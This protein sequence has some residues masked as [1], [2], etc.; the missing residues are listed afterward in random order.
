[1]AHI[2]Q[3]QLSELPTINAPIIGPK[4]GPEKT[5][6]I[7]NAMA[8][9]RLAAFQQ[10]VMIPP[11]TAIGA[12][13]K[14]PENNRPMRIVVTLPPSAGIRLNR[15]DRMT[16]PIRGYLRPNFSERGPNNKGPNIY[17]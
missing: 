15:A 9:L 5:R 7:Q 10:S 6:Q 8:T 1:M 2:V 12:T 11:N 3:R 4:V 16:P 14:K 13:P 17:P